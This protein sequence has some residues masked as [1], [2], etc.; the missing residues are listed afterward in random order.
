MDTKKLCIALD[1]TE[2][3]EAERFLYNLED[4]D[5]IIKVGYSLFVKYGKDITDF[6]K[7]RGFE[8]FLDLKLHDI[9]NTVFNGVKGAVY[10][11]ADYLTIHTLGGINM[12]EKAVE[13]KK[14]SN[15]K[16]L[17]VTVLT[18]HGED[19]TNFIG[20]KF[21]TKELALKLAKIAVDAGIDGIVSSANEVK[22]LKENINKNFISVTPGI[23]LELSEKDDQQRVQSP[24]KAVENGADIIVV[25]RPVI[26]SENP[27]EK[28]KEI[29]KR[30]GI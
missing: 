17:G 3:E 10:S 29:K 4:K 23:R 12:I 14:G 27:N 21:S 19:Y 13:A 11:G 30:M 5:L 28:I 2:I 26:K 20:S 9:P 15:I 22:F 6:V 1:F 7:S 18:S 25:G 16:L 24:E 8:L